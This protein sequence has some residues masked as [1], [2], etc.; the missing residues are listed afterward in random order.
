MSMVTSGG[1][2]RPEGERGEF[3]R[4]CEAAVGGDRFIE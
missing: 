1:R 4:P 3:A 2:G